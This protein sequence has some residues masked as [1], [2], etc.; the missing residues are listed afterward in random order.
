MTAPTRQ[1]GAFVAVIERACIKK[2]RYPNEM[3]ARA[4]GMHY[5]DKGE[6]QALWWYK[7]PHCVGFHLSSNNN[8]RKQNVS[9]FSDRTT[10]ETQR[11]A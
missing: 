2:L 11:T 8:G 9:V 3:T 10:N 1:N 4:A 6:A 5:I 7:C